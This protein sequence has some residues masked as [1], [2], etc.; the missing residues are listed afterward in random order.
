MGSGRRSRRTGHGMSK[1]GTRVTLVVM[2]SSLALSGV[3]SW[4]LRVHETRSIAMHFEAEAQAIAH[5]LQAQVDMSL[6]ALR[7]LA[8]VYDATGT[9]DRR[10]FGVVASLALRR[11]PALYA[12][13]WV[14]RVAGADRAGFEESARQAGQADFRIREQAV[15]GRMVPATERAEYHPVHFVEPL[16]GNETVS[17]YDLASEPIRRAA[18][19]RALATRRLQAT[20][21]LDLVQGRAGDLGF[22]VFLPV[23]SE[24]DEGAGAA[25]PDAVGFVVGVYQV[26]ELFR[27][28]QVGGRGVDVALLDGPLATGGR[29]IHREQPADFAPSAGNGGTIEYRQALD[30]AG[31]SWTVLARPSAE[32]IASR[33]SW[34][35]HGAFVACMLAGAMLAAYAHVSSG[36]TR[37]VERLVAART[38]DLREANERL[39]RQREILQ[40]VLDNLGDG[41]GVADEQGRLVMINPAA[42]QI[43]GLGLIDSGPE[44]WPEVY[45]LYQ[46][47]MKTPVP[48]AQL[49]LARAIAGQASRDVDLFVRNFKRQDG[50]FIRVTATPL[51]DRA[52]E[53]R[54][55]V[56]IFRD[57]SERRWAEGVLRESEARLRAIV[58]A[59]ASGLII[60]SADHRIRE[61]N[62]RAEQIFGVERSAALE[63]D[64]L[65]LCLP[66]EYRMA[67]AADIRRALAGEATLGF[68]T[69][70]VARDGT[71][72]TLLW[73]FSRLADPGN[74]D[75]VVIATGHDITERRQEE[76]ASRVRELA[77]HLQSAREAERSHFAREIHD[78][79]GQALTGLKLEI[80]YLSRLSGR[81]GLDLR[82]RLA[83]LGAMI[84]GTIASM[85][86][87][88]ADLRP[89]IL[90]ELGLVEAIRWQAREFE[91]RT[92][93]PCDVV[94][95]EEVIEL[96]R[97][98][99]TAMFRIFQEAL[100]NIARHSGATRA[101]VRV[102]RHAEQVALEVRDDGRG[103]TQAQASGSRTFG[104]LGMEERARMF[105]GTLRIKSNDPR[106][107]VVFASM[108]G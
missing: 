98:R 91:K 33:R 106:G 25:S 88:A 82:E 100:T 41:V 56:A 78:E 16:A 7:S 30:V 31:R 39:D 72:R 29:V 50:V 9:L 93:I 95:P 85:R 24:P 8:A 66:E 57:I 103:I 63:R 102:T 60:L 73:S 3:V 6:E 69:P 74:R 2:A 87:L 42:E 68:E 28:A 37:A 43:L 49:P 46:P 5:S 47:D 11:H 53:P 67:V 59:T 62:P 61:F 58:E 79:L 36:R 105:G 34:K 81:E 86:R 99:A 65:E 108:P 23:H 44:K 92:E 83:E 107:T 94:V 15:G 27:A 26:R 18:L 17:G 77:A 1:S 35:V 71:E 19:E 40:S 89:Q 76:R 84:D 14:P 52:G 96:G 90:D 38:Q 10:G 104:V 45:G 12:L 13:E 54:G 97:D 21:P 20:E 101:S 55:G 64:F 32:Y 48:A 75:P 22:L 70:V 4:S 80:S 51:K